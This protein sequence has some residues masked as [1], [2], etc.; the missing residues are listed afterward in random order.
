MSLGDT[1]TLAPLLGEGL[2]LVLLALAFAFWAALALTPVTNLTDP[3]PSGVTLPDGVLASP[4]TEK[5]VL[6]AA[7]AASTAAP[8]ISWLLY[9]WSENFMSLS[10]LNLFDDT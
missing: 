7:I 4:D 2:T 1:L 3:L 8:P 10:D 9:F 6:R 5:Y